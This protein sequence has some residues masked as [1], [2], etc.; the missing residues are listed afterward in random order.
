[1]SS[2]TVFQGGS[3]GVKCC[4]VQ[5]S[6]HW[7]VNVEA[8]GLGKNSFSGMAGMQARLECAQ[9]TTG[10]RESKQVFGDGGL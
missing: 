8:T 9:E 3:N 5:K 4:R 6:D 1:M 7:I 10:A 2:K